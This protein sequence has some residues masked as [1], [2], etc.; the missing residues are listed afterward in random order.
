MGPL[1]DVPHV[2]LALGLVERAGIDTV[3]LVHN[4]RQPNAVDRLQATSSLRQ[5]GAT[6]IGITETFATSEISGVAS[7]L[8]PA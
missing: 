8:S 7:T 5:A 2:P 4:M 3:L 6:V 1:L